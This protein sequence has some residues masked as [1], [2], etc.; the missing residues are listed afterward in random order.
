MT[1]SEGVPAPRFK[2]NDPVVLRGSREMGRVVSILAYD[3]GEW[4]YR[5][6]ATGG[7]IARCPEEDLDA[8]DPA[9]DAIET[10]VE[11]G[12]WGTLEAFRRAMAVERISNSNRSTIYAYNAH[13]LLF[14]PYQ[15]KPLLKVLDSPD[16]RLLIA[17]EVGLSKT[18]EAR[19]ILTELQARES[20]EK[21]L[22]VCPSRLREK[23]REELNRKFSQDFEILDRQRMMD[24]LSNLGERRSGR[25][26]RGIISMETLRSPALRE[27]LEARI[28]NIDLVI[29]DEAHH[30]RNQQ[31]N[32]SR[33]FREL[34]SLGQ[35]FILLTATPL[36]LGTQDLFALLRILRPHE[37]TNAESFDQ[38][39]RRNQG[40]LD[41]ARI[42]R[43]QQH[44]RLGEAARR[45]RETCVDGLL[46]DLRDP[47][48]EQVVEEIETGGPTSQR[49]WVE[50]E[51]RVQDL[52]PL[53]T[54]LTR[55][56]KRDVQEHAPERVSKVVLCTFTADE[57]RLYD[58]VVGS[59][60]HGWYS[61]RM[62]IGQIQ[63]AR[64]AA[65]CLPA[66]V[67][68]HAAV[69]ATN[70]DDALELSDIA[71]SDF[72]G[73][74][75]TDATDVSVVASFPVL[76][77]DS[78]YETLRQILRM[79][80][81]D[82]PGAKILIF[83]F[84]KGTTRYL[85]ERLNQDG[86]TALRIDGDIPS[87][88][89]RPDRDERG[90]RVVQFREDS[91]VRIMVSSEVGSEGLDF[92]FAH[93]VVNYDLPWNPMVVEQ[94]IGRIDRFGQESSKVFVHSLVVQG[95]V[96]E[97]ILAR[98]YDRIGIFEKSIG[99]LEVI[100]GETI[101]N[102]QRD[103]L[104]GRLTPEDAEARVDKAARVIENRR[105]E[106]E[107]LEKRASELFGHEEFIKQ[108]LG[109]V[110]Q[111]GRYVTQQALIAVL[112]AFLEAKHPEV[113]IW[114][115]EENVHGMRMTDRLRQDIYAGC[116]TGIEWI[117]RSR[118]GV[119]LFTMDGQTA[120]RRP[121]LELINV[122]H[123]IIAAA[124]ELIAGQLAHPASRI[125]HGTI[126]LTPAEDPD[127]CEGQYFVLVFALQIASIRERR[128]LEVVAWALR[129]ERLVTPEHS[130]RLLH[131][132][133]DIGTEWE[134][135]VP[136]PV[137]PDAWR[138]L[139]REA[140]ARWKQ[141]RENEERENEARYVR[142]TRSLA[143][144][145]RLR[146]GQIQRRIATMQERGREARVIHAT[147]AQ[148]L[149]AEREHEGRMA[150]MMARRRPRVELSDPIAACLVEVRRT[151]GGAP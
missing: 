79:I 104:A 27:E 70:D 39:V 56:R 90:K 24:Y 114:P 48:A 126:R 10:L 101:S 140:R 75:V 20:L 148:L 31:T 84:F 7:R 135:P 8:P 81:A 150:Q 37:Y 28:E 115:E 123:P 3:D 14:E 67:N 88:P 21:V 121:N 92:Q 113:R 46:P 36:H 112:R 138:S 44:G 145:Y 139:D 137:T 12:R 17:D 23:W 29:V 52:H 87:D 86:Y 106:A 74:E 82:D 54:V 43:L 100:I 146:R 108:E 58:A 147:E 107:E 25:R 4:W 45:L 34:G 105:K 26:L 93:H 11:R 5:V 64:Q 99:D 47:L 13:R 9:D 18:I 133:T 85:E 1:A 69:P 60:G 83:S 116:R 131:L 128:V 33:L 51:R 129:D 134:G 38:E 42:V 35:A 59:G 2:A 68:A 118:E 40:V 136:S 91:G 151:D 19:L 78:K 122:S 109:R 143:A 32:T 50:L 97:R 57:E 77:F 66:A 53:A 76:H 49:T 72:A 142:R 41:A 124:I 127:L 61:R 15:Y 149:K 102:L 120:F 110:R 94:R 73:T 95:S 119:L 96:E 117:D 132:L 6:Q 30:G 89:R 130:E 111:F 16:R 63:R 55:T 98:L 65:S 22:V 103:Y 144:D 62:T 141:V 80:D 125:G 71:P